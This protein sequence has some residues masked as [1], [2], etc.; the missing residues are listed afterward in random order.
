P[1]L[2][3]RLLEEC[4]H[5]LHDLLATRAF[6]VWA[7]LGG[8]DGDVAG[9]DRVSFS[10]RLKKAHLRY[11]ATALGRPRP[12][13]QRTESTPR[14]RPSGTASHL[15]LFESPAVSTFCYVTPSLATSSRT[16][17]LIS[18]S[19]ATKAALERSRGCGM[20]TY[21]LSLMVP[22]RVAMTTMRS[23]RKMGPEMLWVTK[24]TVFLSC[25]Q[26]RSS[27]SCITSRV[28]ASRAPKGS[29]MRRRDGC[30]ASTRAMATRCFIPPDSSRGY[31]SSCSSRPTRAR[32][33]RG[34]N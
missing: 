23:A 4:E 3:L 5:P 2:L 33:R 20:V 14:E 15:D 29:S 25:S 31:L 19:R 21:T 9:H 7:H 18:R 27:S 11:L 13:A 34:T 30:L 22:G 28:W 1:P 8:G 6:V 17:R 10:V 32:E 12:H 16:R 24:A 26:M